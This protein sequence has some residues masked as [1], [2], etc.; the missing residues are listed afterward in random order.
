MMEN[1]FDKNL[2]FEWWN[3]LPANWKK[4]FNFFIN[5]PKHKFRLSN[6]GYENYYNF[7]GI[8]YTS[9]ASPSEIHNFIKYHGTD[10]KPNNL[11][12]QEILDTKHF[13][14]DLNGDFWFINYDISPIMSLNKLQKLTIYKLAI[15]DKNIAEIGNLSE[16]TELN[17]GWNFIRDVSVFKTLKNLKILNLYNNPISIDNINDLKTHLPNCK[18][19]YSEKYYYGN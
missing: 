4:I 13:H 6:S 14:L 8:K 16:L 17:L 18:I 2:D 5:K 7:L 1:N 10:E 3:N 12:L 15:N 11:E 19:I 9:F